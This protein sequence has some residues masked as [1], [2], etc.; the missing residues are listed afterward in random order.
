MN[1]TNITLK[2]NLPQAFKK[3]GQIFC[4]AIKTFLIS[5]PA[6]FVRIYRLTNLTTKIYKSEANS[7]NVEQI[8]PQVEDALAQL[9]INSILGR[10]EPSAA[11][12][13]TQVLYIYPTYEKYSD[14]EKKS[15]LNV[16]HK[17]KQALLTGQA[18]AL[19]S[20]Y[21][22]TPKHFRMDVESLI[23]SWQADELENWTAR[24]SK[25]RK[26]RDF[27]ILTSK[28]DPRLS[29]RLYRE[30]KNITQR[31]MARTLGTNATR[32]SR[33]ERGLEGP[34]LYERSILTD[35]VGIP[36]DAWTLR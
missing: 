33:I 30:R 25:E 17:L 10:P 4:L 22:Q 6:I 9:A 7:E 20:R 13:R 2:Q 31:H 15:I 18:P 5:I 1:K 26:Y 12:T 11:I 23:S 36:E 19:G 29:L 21:W 32:Y 34:Y 3:K 16:T 14:G 24:T 27:F 35:I 28:D 8:W